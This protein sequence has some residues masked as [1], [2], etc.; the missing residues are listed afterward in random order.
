MEQNSK[1]SEEETVS[2]TTEEAEEMNYNIFSFKTEFDKSKTNEKKKTSTKFSIRKFLKFQLNKEE[3][4]EEEFTQSFGEMSF[5]NKN[6][7]KFDLDRKLSA[8]VLRSEEEKMKE[9]LKVRNS[10]S[11]IVKVKESSTKN[12]DNQNTKR[13]VIKNN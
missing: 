6:I 1:T 4:E 9:I 10:P 5:E 11:I 2:E 3:L 12:K 7:Q 8:P 13:I